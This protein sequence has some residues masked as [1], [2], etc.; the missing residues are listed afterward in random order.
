MARIF[1]SYRRADSAGY[2][3]RL[4]DHLIRYFDPDEIFLDVGTIKAGEDFESVI[5]QVVGSCD[6][7]IAVIGPRWLEILQ[8]KGDIQK[9]Y[10]RIEIRTALNRDILVVPALV[11]R[12]SMPNDKD[13]PNDLKALRRR[14]AIEL[15]HDRFAYDVDRLVEAIGG[16]KAKVRVSL[17]ASYQSLIRT[18]I[19]NPQE[20][21]EVLID[22][23]KVGKI[24]G[25]G[26]SLS[27]SKS[28]QEAWHPIET[29]VESGLHKIS[30]RSR[31]SEFDSGVR[32]NELSFRIRGGQ[33]ITFMIE[34]ESSATGGSKVVLRAHKP[35]IDA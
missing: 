22:R 4:H 34:R 31:K 24:E 16:A 21:F 25:P 3:G 13:L 15:S 32:S 18:R 17:G 7:L 29:Q 14:H 20:V 6:A 10:L 23:K 5:D 30:I 11:E 27:R 9:D 19:L 33:S 26:I 28:K 35:I 8:E 12:A 1:I 2:V